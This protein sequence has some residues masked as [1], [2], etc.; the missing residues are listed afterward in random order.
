MGGFPKPGREPDGDG[1]PE[2]GVIHWKEL[3]GSTLGWGDEKNQGKRPK[4]RGKRK[5]LL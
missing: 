4:V 5:R 3:N 1:C 2:P